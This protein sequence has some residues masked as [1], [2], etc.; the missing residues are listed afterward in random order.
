MV[1]VKDDSVSYNDVVDAVVEEPAA[2]EPSAEAPPETVVESDASTEGPVV[3]EVIAS[4]A[5]KPAVMATC[6]ACGKV[7]TAKNLKY[8]HKHIC[9]ASIH[10]PVELEVPVPD[11]PPGLVED[12]DAV[13]ESIIEPKKYII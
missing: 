6:E 8:A 1:D 7:M 4:R 5:K 10:A 13:N 9:P 11:E 3:Q 12:T 2:A